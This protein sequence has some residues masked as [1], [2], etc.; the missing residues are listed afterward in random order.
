M[1]ELERAFAPDIP[2]PGTTSHNRNEAS[3]HLRPSMG[4]KHEILDAC[5]VQ[6]S[7]DP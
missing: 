2:P 3:V 7:N 1:N 4:E 5:A 6:E